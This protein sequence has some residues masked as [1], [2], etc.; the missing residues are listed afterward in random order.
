VSTRRSLAL[1]SAMVAGMLVAAT[2]FMALA[3]P[4][5]VRI[6]QTRPRP[7]T[8]PPA[9]LFSH[10]AHGQYRCYACHPSLFPQTLQSFTHADM[11]AG[12]FCGRCHDGHE[13]QAVTRT[14]CESCHAPH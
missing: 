4:D 8:P 13:A 9:A 6:P 1:A 2:S 12:R 10:V 14:P 3:I 11:N 5:A 7:S